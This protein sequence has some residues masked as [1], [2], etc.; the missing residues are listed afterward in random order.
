MKMPRL[1][2]LSDGMWFIWLWFNVSISP[3]M[4]EGQNQQQIMNQYTTVIHSNR[5]KKRLNPIKD[6]EEVSCL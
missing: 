1:A 4:N 6:E 5:S 3:D 2:L